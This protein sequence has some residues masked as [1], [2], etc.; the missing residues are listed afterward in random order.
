MTHRLMRPVEIDN[1]RKSRYQ[2]C[3]LRLGLLRPLA[4]YGQL[5]SLQ[6][7]TLKFSKI[8]PLSSVFQGGCRS[9]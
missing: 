1:N 8:L 5:I 9:R 3:R 2:R 4:S 6:K 7:A